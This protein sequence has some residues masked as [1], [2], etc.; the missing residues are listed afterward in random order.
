MKIATV[1][2]LSKELCCRGAEKSV[3]GV[4]GE[5]QAM[6]LFLRW[7]ILWYL[8]HADKRGPVKSRKCHSSG[9][10]GSVQKQ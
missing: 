2:T 10:E 6:I 3:D 7:E 9:K 5:G 8:F 4:D 1:I